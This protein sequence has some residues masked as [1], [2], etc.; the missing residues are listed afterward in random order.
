MKRI[1][2][3]VAI[4][5]SGVMG[6][7]IAC[8]FAGIGIPVLLLDVPADGNDKNKIVNDYLSA[9]KDSHPSP[10]Y[11]KE[12]IHHITTGNFD[13]D[14]PQ[15]STCDWIIE[16]IIENIEIK[17]LLFDQ[18]EQYRKPESLVST[19]TSGIPIHTM[20]EGRSEDFKKH[21]CGT[22]FFNPPRYLRL[23]EIIPAPDTDP[24]VI[25]FIMDYGSN[26]L[27]KNMVLAKDTPAFI[28]NRIGVYI[29][30]LTFS[31]MEKWQLS[32]DE[33]EVLTGTVMGR[34]KSAT[35]R[36]ADI[37]GIDTLLTVANGI[38]EN[39]P[40]DEAREIF[41]IPA[42]MQEMVENNWLGD[43]TG[44]G[45]FKK[46][47][48]K[49]DQPEILVLNLNT[50]EYEKR[51]E[52]VFETVEIANQIN[53]LSKRLPILLSGTDKAG[54]FYRHFYYGLFTYISHRIP[55][56]SDDIYRIGDAM[57]A[58][59]GWQ[60]GPFEIW[61]T[62]GVTETV[63]AMQETGFPIALWVQEM[64]TSG[65]TSFYKMIGNKKM[66][67]DLPT[68]SYKPLSTQN[69]FIIL[70]NYTDKIIWKNDSC[71]LYD[72]RDDVV[73]LEWNTQ[74]DY[75]NNDLL[76]GLQQAIDEA[77]KNYKG[78]ILANSSTDFSLG[79]DAQTIYTLA[80]GKQ[81]KEIENI[82][83]NFQDTYMRIKYSAIPVIAAVHGI[84]KNEGYELSLY[85]DR[86]IAAAETYAGLGQIQI[87]L[88]P[89][90]GG[91]TQLALRTAAVAYT[92]TS[93]NKILQNHF[94]NIVHASLFSSAQE[95]VQTRL[96]RQGID[97]VV[98]NQKRLISNAKNEIIN[99]FDNG[100]IPPVKTN[101][102]KILGRVALSPMLSYIH[103]EL[104]SNYMTNYDASIA[105]KLAYVICGGDVS[106]P[107]FVTEGYMLDLEK[108]AFLSICGESK[109]LQRLEAFVKKGTIIRN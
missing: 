97:A 14:L 79:M 30:M 22:H 95:A 96:Y 53:D 18:V 54:E 6:T 7:R 20:T 44:Q 3:K 66:V 105:R 32:I 103:N 75:I 69:A 88:I 33:I 37:I 85:T 82:I 81:Y 68:K 92:T 47:I 34:P 23:L 52:P 101:R 4:L 25:D 5:G 58:G 11:T 36:T 102:L 12:A 98:I 55:E 77:E 65:H 56:I 50:M 15:I 99:T 80:A 61:D 87:G 89:A 57:K 106:E 86:V 67:Y 38:H 43:K 64:I 76:H 31:L 41:T 21:F 107:N 73:V 100:Y 46:I 2:K 9:A 28:A 108:E 10:L 29:T 60:M 45:F 17:K 74:E 49:R 51:R 59:F 19:N 1:I 84:T 94:D 13:D 26:I 16:T 104:R 72:I 42:W 39:C 8:H 90:C 27:G 35:F 109:T 63:K 78:L 62:L 70:Q 91:I 93:A 40:L 48:N 83:N 24:A 71:K